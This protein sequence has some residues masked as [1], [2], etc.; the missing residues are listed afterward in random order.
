MSATDQGYL[1]GC[2]AACRALFEPTTRDMMAPESQAWAYLIARVDQVALAKSLKTQLTGEKHRSHFVARAKYQRALGFAVGLDGSW[3]NADLPVNFNN[4]SDKK[5]MFCSKVTEANP[6]SAARDPVSGMDNSDIVEAVQEA[7]QAAAAASDPSEFARII[8]DKVSDSSDGLYYAR[9]DRPATRV[10]HHKLVQWLNAHQLRDVLVDLDRVTSCCSLC[11]NIWDCRGRMRA[12]LQDARVIARGAVSCKIGKQAKVVAVPTDSD[13]LM[14]T[15]MGSMIAYYLHAGLGYL[16]ENIPD[17]PY[18][19]N[20]VGDSRQ[21][22]VMLLWLPV[23]VNCMFRELQDPV[24][25]PGRA[26][27]GY[28]NYVGCLE[29]LMSYYCYTC[30]CADS[31]LDLRGVPFEMFHVFHFKELSEFP[32]WNRG[33]RVHDFVFGAPYAVAQD[34]AAQISHVS[35]KLQE[36]Y[37]FH[38]HPVLLVL[39][40]PRAT[41]REVLGYFAT[42]QEI[43]ELTADYLQLSA[44]SPGSTQLH[45]AQAGVHAVT[46][47]LRRALAEE[48]GPTL[49]GELDRWT[50]ARMQVEWRN[51]AARLGG[52]DFALENAQLIYYAQ[53]T[54][55]PPDTG[56]LLAIAAKSDDDQDGAVAQ[57]RTL[58][59]CS[60]WKAAARLRRYQFTTPAS[61]ADGDE[62][63]DEGLAG[64]GSSLRL[65]RITGGLTSSPRQLAASTA[66][67]SARA[68]PASAAAQ[69]VA[70]RQAGRR[71]TA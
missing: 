42:R 53:H 18:S 26:A 58:G 50:N 47:Q 60:P 64:L 62:A 11:N 68:R 8:V 30:A 48:A 35:D 39:T 70:G 31:T 15:A 27:K 9:W 14:Q 17:A 3:I 63:D 21:T 28:H 37:E 19:Q 51:V 16:S 43:A 49:A 71:S 6:S 5:D 4:A 34:Y 40:E 45:L 24:A 38:V 7:R 52:A 20:L 44:S 10:T 67:R 36:L 59:L 46:W 56:G 23:H 13:K 57:L 55:S 25:S 33:K 66:R 69:G 12:T 54:L 29:L 61:P 22:V 65:L 1:F 41:D 32:G 2:C